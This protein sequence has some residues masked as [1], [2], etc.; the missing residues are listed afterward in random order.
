MTFRFRQFPVYQEA[1]KL[2]REIVLLTNKF[3]SQFYYLKDQ[4][5]RSSL[6]VVL[7]IAEGSSKRSDK[8]LNRY[9]ENSM[10]SVNE[11]VSALEIS[12]DCNLVSKIKFD[13]LDLRCEQVVKQLGGFS[14]SLFVKKKL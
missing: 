6:S 8:D 10:G 5:N 14:R 1:K 2:H 11:T 13:E 7:N 9:L 4:I 12:L 3:P